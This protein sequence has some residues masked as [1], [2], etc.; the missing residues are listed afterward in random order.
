V[1]DRR[2]G[3]AMMA[4]GQQSLKTRM[5]AANV[6]LPEWAR[7]FTTSEMAVLAVIRDECDR[8]NFCTLILGEIAERAGRCIGKSWLQK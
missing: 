5:L 6:A 8:S 3:L 7:R 2:G 4:D 1:A